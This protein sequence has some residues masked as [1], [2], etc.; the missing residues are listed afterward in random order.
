MN[1]IKDVLN[2][3]WI[4]KIRK[5]GLMCVFSLSLFFKEYINNK[6]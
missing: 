5:E 1:S 2:N 3:I 6:L 4:K